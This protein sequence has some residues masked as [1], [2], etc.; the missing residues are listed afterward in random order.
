MK[1]SVIVP[2]YRVEQT[3]ARCVESV[4]AQTFTD[5]ELLLIDDGSDDDCPRLCDAYAQADSRV[6]V[7][8]Q[9]NAGLGAARNCGID[10][11]QGDALLFLDSD[12]CLSADT[13]E[14]TN[15]ALMQ[16]DCPDFVEFPVYEHYGSRQAHLL[17][18]PECTY[19]DPWDYWLV[20]K[21]YRHSYACNKL[22]RKHVFR[23]VRFREGKKFEDAYTL[24][25]ILAVCHRY[26]TVTCG[27]YY[28]CH[29]DEGITAMAGP[30]ILHLLEA[31]VRVLASLQWTCPPHIP[32]S[33]FAEYYAYLLNIQVDAYAHHG[34]S[35][36]LLKR[37][38]YRS[39]PKSLLAYIIGIKNL[40]R[41]NHLYHRLCR[42]HP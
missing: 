26:A 36:I 21:A 13:L 12:D 20:G 3:L 23:D 30:D 37:L 31:H 25:D 10:M 41:L 2:V 32:P 5:W 1:I 11:A 16:D 7:C 24:P 17:R 14:L 38:P 42:K 19:T 40:C 34:D 33:A 15:E 28:Y 27:L 6:R 8:H 4:F 35:G 39:T 9:P 22:F 29:N 18:L